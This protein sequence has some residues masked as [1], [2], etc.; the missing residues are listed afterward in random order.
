M[1]GFGSEHRGGVRVRGGGLMV[2]GGR[3]IMGAG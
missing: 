3:K 2:E 1:G